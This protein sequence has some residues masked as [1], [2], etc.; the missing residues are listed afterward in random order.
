MTQALRANTSPARSRRWWRPAAVA[1]CGLPLPAVA[2]SGD[3]LLA[4]LV[5]GR[6]PEVT[7][8][9]TADVAGNPW[10][11][12]SAHVAD[13]LGAALRVLLPDGRGW[14][15]S[16]LGKPAI[17]LHA[18]FPH[19]APLPLAHGPGEPA[20]EWYTASWTWRPS[21]SPLR[22][23]VPADSKHTLLFWNVAPGSPEPA[24]GWRMLLSSDRTSSI[25]LAVAPAPLRWSAPAFAAMGV[26]AAGLLLQGFLLWKRVRRNSVR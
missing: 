26:A 5:L 20:P 19:P 22:F 21:A 4:R 3:L 15:L 11:K 12:D 13:A 9:V 10:L 1:L 6:T 18:T 17:L 16:E 25:P 2:H 8:E 7:L 24:A 14:T 23:E